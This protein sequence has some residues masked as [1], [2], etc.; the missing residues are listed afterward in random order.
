MTRNDSTFI[1]KRFKFEAEYGQHRNWWVRDSRIAGNPLTIYLF[2]LSHDPQHMPT[3]TEAL[4]ALD[5]GRSAWQAAKERLLQAG[6]MMEIRDRYPSGYVDSEGRPKGGQKRFRLELLD[7]EPNI[8]C[9]LSDMVI[10][11]DIPLEEYENTPV[12]N[13]CGKSAVAESSQ[14]GKSAVDT[15]PLVKA[16][17]ENQQWPSASADNQQSFIGRENGLVRF[18]SNNQPTSTEPTDVGAREVLDQVDAQL[19]ALL[20]T[21]Q[22]PLTYAAIAHEVDGRLDLRTIDLVQAVTDTVLRQRGRIENPAAYV[23]SVLVRKPTA[24]IAGNV[25]QAPGA[26]EAID[27]APDNEFGPVNERERAAEL[28]AACARGEHD[29]GPGSWPEVDRGHC[30]RAACLVARRSVDAAFAVLEAAELEGS[31]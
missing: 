8:T 24:W 25:P 14:C 7:P 9:A 10:E 13:Q 3:Q 12:Q 2:L 11:L 28:A 30:T 26:F 21:V 6:F 16:S 27:D 19:A 18:G 29:W 5:I 22:P 17:A 20:P 1:R 15:K 31:M 4:K 23:A